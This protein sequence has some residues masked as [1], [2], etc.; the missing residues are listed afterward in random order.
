MKSA[1]YG[2]T[3]QEDVDVWQRLEQLIDKENSTMQDVLENFPVYVRRVNMARFLAHYELFKMIQ[4][5]PG[6]IVECGVFRGASL[7]SFAKFLEI[8]NSG[9]RARKVYGFD[10]FTGFEGLH[11]KD[12]K[13]DLNVGKTDGGWAPGVKYD[14]LKEHVAIFQ[15]DCYVPRSQRM[16]LEPGDLSKTAPKFMKD[17]PGL[18]I[19]LLHLD[20]DVYEPT[21]AA[22]E[23]FYPVVVKGGLVVIDEFAH[24]TWAGETSAVEDYF[25][26]KMPK[27]QKFPF[28]SL[29]G[30]FFIKE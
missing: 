21:L 27:I 4:D 13:V 20:V 30:G 22:L 1:N 6:H 15:Q 25:K 3:M 29:P 19:S 11:E 14:D 7:F 28:I 5:L 9:D 12:G 18:R 23:A 10:N 16:F 24:T 17:N 8:F 2:S 26:D